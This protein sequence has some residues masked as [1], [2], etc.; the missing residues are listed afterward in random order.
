[1]KLVHDFSITAAR[2]GRRRIWSPALLFQSGAVGAWFDPSD[3]SSLF[4]DADGT[5]PVTAPDQPVGR[6]LDKSGHGHDAYQSLASARPVYRRH[7]GYHWLEF[8]GVDDCLQM[9][10]PVNLDAGHVIAGLK[11]PAGIS[12]HSGLLSASAAGYLAITGNGGDRS[13]GKNAGGVIHRV[14]T[15]SVFPM[16]SG[17]AASIRINGGALLCRR[18]GIATVFAN[19]TPGSANLS[20]ARTLMA[21]T[22]T[23]QLPARVDMFGLILLETGLSPEQTDTCLSYVSSRMM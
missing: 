3:M 19:A 15:P 16:T 17:T 18:R 23:G 10:S 12:A 8:D 1:M 6:I 13:L 14:D 22:S 11:E 7:S 9:A 20:A 2:S 4:Q 21:F 5:L